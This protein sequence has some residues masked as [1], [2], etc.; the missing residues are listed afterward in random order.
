MRE[1]GLVA[2]GDAVK[3]DQPLVEIQTDKA[4]TEMP[5]PA[6]G[7]VAE[8][9]GLEGDLLYVGDMLLVIDDGKA[10]VTIVG[11][12]HGDSHAAA[13]VVGAPVALAAGQPA[14][15]APTA[16]APTA[17]APTAETAAVPVATPAGVAP[18]A[19]RPLATPFREI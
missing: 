6:T 7:V 12:A 5:A 13:P 3:E 2:V 11:G 8:L 4:V 9:G 18:A 16:V 17:V 19:T 1:T 15:V 10:A 14:P